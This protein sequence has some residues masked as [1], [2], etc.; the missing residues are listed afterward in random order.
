[1]TTKKTPK[2]KPLTKLEAAERKASILECAVYQQYNDIDEQLAI[3]WMIRKE[4]ESPTPNMYQLRNALNA[5][6]GMLISNQ[7]LMMDCAGLEY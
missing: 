3:L 5:F 7:S 2:A 1:M 6:T 4:A